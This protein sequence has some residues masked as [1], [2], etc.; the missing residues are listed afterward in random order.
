M[1]AACDRHFLSNINICLRG[2]SRAGKKGHYDKKKAALHGRMSV[3]KE[4]PRSRGRKTRVKSENSRFQ[5]TFASR[6]C[7][8][9]CRFFCLCLLEGAEY[10][11]W[12]YDPFVT[13][14]IRS[15]NRRTK[16]F[17][18]VIHIRA[19]RYF[20]RLLRIPDTVYAPI[21]DVIRYRLNLT[22]IHASHRPENWYRIQRR[23]FIPLRHS[24]TSINVWY[25]FQFAASD[26]INNYTSRALQLINC[27]ATNNGSL[28][29]DI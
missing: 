29:C 9:L 4:R 6:L 25:A 16:Y 17:S 27:T 1:R 2:K 11:I 12:K 3:R 10:S 21:K 7:L 18:Q 20:F 22:R 15:K 14:N 26:A 8:F 13:S 24:L 28:H 19:I 23:L 5:T